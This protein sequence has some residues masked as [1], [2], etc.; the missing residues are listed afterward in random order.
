[1]SDQNGTQVNT[2]RRG[3]RTANKKNESQVSTLPCPSDDNE[4][5]WIRYWKQQG[6]PWRIK[7]EINAE[8]QTYLNERRRRVLNE[9][10]EW[11]YPLT[12]VPL[13]RADIEWLLATHANGRGPVDSADPEQSGRPGLDLC[14]ADL[15]GVDLRWLP[16]AHAIFVNAHLEE[17][18][19]YNVHLERADF[20]GAHLERASLDNAY[21]EGASLCRA[22]LENA[23]LNYA[24]LEG[25]FLLEAHLEGAG[26]HGVHLEGAKLM[27]AH[28]E[29]AYLNQSF[30]DV[31]TDLTNINL[32]NQEMGGAILADVHWGN[33]D[34]TVVDNWSTLSILGDERLARREV[35]NGTPESRLLILGLYRKATRAYRQLATAL[36]NQGLNDEAN[37]FAYYAQL[38]QR[39]V[40]RLKRHH[41]QYFAS[42]VID[43]LS[44]YGYK[45][46]RSFR[47][48]LIVILMFAVAY[49]IIG[50]T[51]GPALSPLGSVVFSMT[52]FHGRGFFPGGITLDDP[53][54]VFAAGEAFVGL[55]IE[56]TFIATLTR[57]LFGG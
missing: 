36:R 54:T 31:E 28:L 24:R 13:S 11:I 49:F 2:K 43:L 37:H 48:Y 46:K 47:A 29:G 20:N 38:M 30:L 8:R 41:W 50:L 27:N 6:Q 44:G 42:L 51:V 40:Y 10:G 56:V 9:A 19:L 17:A 55:V 3:S 4:G 39:K 22:H 23:S 1:M 5:K 7:P 33:V 21:L 45:L 26:L 52:S 14:G 15:R 34:L 35:N 16:L 32:F 12:D 57:R 18:K 53:L 25:A